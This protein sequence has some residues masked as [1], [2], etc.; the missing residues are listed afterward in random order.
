[1]FYDTFEPVIIILGWNPCC[2]NI[3]GAAIVFGT[4]LKR[5]PVTLSLLFGLA[6][7]TSPDFTLLGISVNILA[8]WFEIGDWMVIGAMVFWVASGDRLP[9]QCA[10]LYFHIPTILLFLFSCS[11]VSKHPHRVA[12][13]LPNFLTIRYFLKICQLLNKKNY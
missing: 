11:M 6:D 1:M 9:N 5:Y 12:L 8:D 2:N 13:L 3:A 10:V 7:W 4:F